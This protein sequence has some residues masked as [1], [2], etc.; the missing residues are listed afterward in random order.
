MYETS[1][2]HT[3]THTHTH[4]LTEEDWGDGLRILKTYLPDECDH[5]TKKNDVVHYHYVGRLGENGNVF[6]RRW[7][8]KSDLEELLLDV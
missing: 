8:Q 5:M 2:T 1:N 3:H 6:G 7:R 4:S